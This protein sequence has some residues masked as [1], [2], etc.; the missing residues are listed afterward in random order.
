MSKG[1]TKTLGILGGG[2]LGRMT[3]MAAARLGIKTYIYCPDKDCP[4]S[5]VAAKTFFH[6][7]TDKRQLKA[8]AKSVDVI[9]YEFENIPVE[10]IQYLQKL[11]PVYP[12]DRLLEIS[13]ERTREKQF[14]NDIGIKT[15]TW[16]SAS[17]DDDPVEVQNKINELGCSEYIIKTTRFGYDG[18]GQV[19]CQKSDNFAEKWD[20]LN[21]ADII[22]EQVIDFSCEISVIVCRDKLGQT[23]TY[24]PSLNEHKNHILFKSTVPAPIPE[25]IARKAKDM[26]VLLADAVDLVGVLA[27]EM[28][29]TRDG[30]LLANEIAPRPHNSGHWTIDACAVSQFEQHAR[31]VCGLTVGLPHRHS[32]AV[33]VNLLG[34]DAR[35]K[36]LSPWSEIKGACLHLYGK[37]EIRDG[38]KMGHVTV[39]KPLEDTPPVLDIDHAQDS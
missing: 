15:T 31:T 29:L 12:D 27:L 9:T 37:A 33:M 34:S 10:T 22:I 21:R 7:Y 5:H 26:A 17:P 19:F 2:Q 4:A 35:E 25:P 32:N 11:T 23:V 36:N 38:R 16:L 14:L 6:D 28:F 20:E 39:L 1:H 3:A 13:Q 18:K 8:F 24:G 30:E